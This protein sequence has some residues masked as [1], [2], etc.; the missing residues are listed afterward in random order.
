MLTWALLLIG[1][2]AQALTCEGSIVV[3]V[4]SGGV[5][6]VPFLVCVYVFMYV[7]HEFHFYDMWKL[8]IPATFRDNC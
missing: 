5:H 3:P 4:L 1:V 8:G 7:L 2:L 6:R